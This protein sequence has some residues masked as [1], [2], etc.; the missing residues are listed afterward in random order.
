MATSAGSGYSS[1]WVSEA[2]LD[3]A[4]WGYC[5][6][7]VGGIGPR[8][9]LHRLGVSDSAIRTATCRD[10]GAQVSELNSAYGHPRFSATATFVMG[11]HVILAE[12]PRP[13]QDL[14]QSPALSHVRRHR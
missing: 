6:T 13:R 3:V 10:L 4:G 11:E 14:R 9:A 7:A 2:G 12:R 8:E 1:D 5:I